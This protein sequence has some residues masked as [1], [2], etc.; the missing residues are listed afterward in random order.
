MSSV[1]P[2]TSMHAKTHIATLEKEY[3]CTIGVEVRDFETGATVAEYKAHESV[4]AASCI[5]LFVAGAVLHSLEG[6]GYTLES[7]LPIESSHL[8]PGASILADL[9]IRAMSIR[10]LLYFLLAH[11]DTS[12]QNV[13]EQVAGPE[14][15]HAYIQRI[16]CADTA[17]VPKYAS[18]SETHSRTTPH[19]A[20]HFMKALWQ[21]DGILPP[22]A[23]ALILSFLARS[24][25]T[26][27]G[28]RHLPCTLNTKEPRIT[29]HYSKAGKIGRSVNDTLILTT[30]TGVLGV[31]VFIDNLAV[32]KNYNNVDHDGI[33]LV[34]ALVRDLFAS[35]DKFETNLT[36]VY[37]PTPSKSPMHTPGA[38]IFH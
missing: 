13:L 34:A 31:A 21:G 30:K 17:Y 33:L 20:V 5:K 9:A 28:L 15:I 36:P 18:N 29:E 16:G 19:D 4:T 8:V 35:W 37:V 7:T 14:L 26:H 1:Q 2:E 24:R 11:S 38:A 12:A 10:D 25:H 3:G 32:T 27:F 6:R 22:E 23:R